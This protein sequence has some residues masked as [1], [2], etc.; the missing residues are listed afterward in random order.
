MPSD[1]Y[2]GEGSLRIAIADFKEAITLAVWNSGVAC[3]QRWHME[4]KGN[5]QYPTLGVASIGNGHKTKLK[6]TSFI[7]TTR[8]AAILNNTAK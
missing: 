4:T 5:F 8:C 1:T 3:A 7:I 6:A 2:E